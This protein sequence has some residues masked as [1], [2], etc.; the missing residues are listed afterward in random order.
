MKKLLLFTLI[1]SFVGIT[2]CTK[3]EESIEIS[4]EEKELIVK[5]TLIEFNKSAIKTGKLQ[6]LMNSL[7]QKSS[8]ENLSSSEVEILFQEFLGEQSQSFLDLYYQLEAM[9]MNGEEF[10]NIAD[11]FEYLKLEMRNSLDKSSSRSCDYSSG[12]LVGML[13]WLGVCEQV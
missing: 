8:S 9:N 6:K 12:L 1:F 4:Q 13:K 5:Q 7:T 10:A 11:Q 2:S 3:D